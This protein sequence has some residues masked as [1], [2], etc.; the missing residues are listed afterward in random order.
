DADDLVFQERLELDPLVRLRRTDQG[1]LHASGKE[2][3][4]DLA[5]RRHLDL[6]GD[7]RVRAPE[8]AERVRQEVDAW[9]GRGAE[10]DRAGLQAR[11]RVEV[12]LC[13]SEA[14][15]RL[16]GSSREHLAGLGQPAAAA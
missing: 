12:F 13:R 2:A 6:D 4:E 16:R 15:Q 1:E 11:E 14:R 8:A 3:T 7:T 10:V 5:A 9:S